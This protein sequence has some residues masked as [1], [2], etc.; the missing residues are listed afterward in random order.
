MF[1][2]SSGSNGGGLALSGQKHDLEDN[3]IY[4]NQAGA[5][6]GGVYFVGS[7]G[8]LLKANR[9]YNNTTAGSGGGGYFQSIAN[10][11]LAD[12]LIYGNAADADGGGIGLAVSENVTLVNDAVLDNH[13]TGNDSFGAGIY[14]ASSPNLRLLHATLARNGGGSAI[15]LINYGSDRVTTAL[16]NTLI[17]S[18]SVGI[19]VTGISLVKINGILWHDTP[20]TVSR[21]P[22]A[23]VTVQNQIQGNPAFAADGYHLTANSQAIDRGVAAG[24]TSDIDG[25]TRPSGGAPDLGADEYTGP[26][27]R[28]ATPT[29]S[30]SPT[31]TPTATITVTRTPTITGT[32]QVYRRVYLPLML[33]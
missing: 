24:V 30:A 15:Y 32:A 10:M 31:S 7:D 1:N 18:H 16:T 9:I 29:P 11:L 21:E 33:R 20:I 13:V 17:S 12:N 23:T 14:A 27:T 5:D 26:G 3:H 8:D 28:T 19:N 22:A 2:N 25:E 6:G 4:H